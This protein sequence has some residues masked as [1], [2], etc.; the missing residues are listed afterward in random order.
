MTTVH[1]SKGQGLTQALKSYAMN[2]GYDVS[3]IKK[4]DWLNTID[5]L[6]H[7][8]KSREENRISILE[9]EKNPDINQ[10]M[11]YALYELPDIYTEVKT[12]KPYGNMRVYE[13]DIEFTDAELHS[14]LNSMGLET[15]SEAYENW[16]ISVVNNYENG[17]V[18]CGNFQLKSDS[19]HDA[20]SYNK[21]LA[22]FADEYI[23]NYDNNGDGEIS[24]DEFMAFETKQTTENIENIDQEVFN[25]VKNLLKPVFTHLN[26]DTESSKDTIDKKE[27]MNFMLSMDALDDDKNYTADG[28]IQPATFSLMNALLADDGVNGKKISNFLSENYN[29][30]RNQF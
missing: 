14:L 7:I 19:S 6:E 3:G 4:Q 18:G 21:D 13:G 30:Y 22:D 24:F 1:V 23:K 27:V 25:E 5:R 12:N 20:E 29:T 8:Q 15:K 11:D 16:T 26:V 28:Y 9:T 10:V 2:N 17:D